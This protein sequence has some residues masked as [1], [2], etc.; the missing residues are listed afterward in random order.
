MIFSLVR[1]AVL[2]SEQAAASQQTCFDERGVSSVNRV[3]CVPVLY[4]NG[5][6][7]NCCYFLYILIK[8]CVCDV[9]EETNNHGNNS[10]ISTL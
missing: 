2:A 3:L 10:I 6:A 1:K 9:N 7:V 4:N 8:N 5:P